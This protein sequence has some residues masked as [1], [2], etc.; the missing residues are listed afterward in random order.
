MINI[1]PSG[2]ASPHFSDKGWASE[3]LK[4]L[5][6]VTLCLSQTQAVWYAQY[7]CAHEPQSGG[8]IGREAEATVPKA[9][10]PSKRCEFFLTVP[11]TK[12]RSLHFPSCP[13]LCPDRASNKSSPTLDS[14]DMTVGPSPTGTYILI[15]LKEGKGLHPKR[16]P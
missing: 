10:L 6:D 16:G 4:D 12:L 5:F 9:A 1:Y 11:I 7:Y 15:A 13:Q 8:S 2:H 3:V 14:L